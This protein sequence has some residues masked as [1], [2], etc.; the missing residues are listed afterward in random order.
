[1]RTGAP[2][3]AVAISGTQQAFKKFRPTVTIRYS[4]PFVIRQSGDRRTR[5][6][7]SQATDQIMYQIAALLPP[8]ARGPY[9]NTLPTEAASLTDPASALTDPASVDHQ[10]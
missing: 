1:M 8:A 7:L 9:G 10:A 3:V 2:V 5:D 6:S 4:R